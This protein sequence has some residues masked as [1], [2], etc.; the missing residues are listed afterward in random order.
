MNLENTV[1]IVA[2]LGQLK[3]YKVVS[4]LGIDRHTDAK[5]S[6]ATSYTQEKLSINFELIKE[7]DYISAHK[8]ISEEMSDNIGRTGEPHNMFLEREKK[9][10]KAV[11]GD[12]KS[13]ID[14]EK[15]S[16][17]FLAFPKETINQLVSMLD[18]D[19]QK[20]L[21]KSVPSNLTKIDKSELQGY[22]I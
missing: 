17:W 3:V 18:S 20:I 8:R 1:V 14:H 13:V 11:A 9:D 7:V 6:S 5:V 16:S 10:L 4:K 2:D 19:V 12:I 15:P 22:F 21:I